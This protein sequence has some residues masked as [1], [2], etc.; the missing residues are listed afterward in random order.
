LDSLVATTLPS[1]RLQQSAAIARISRSAHRKCAGRLKEQGE[2]MAQTQSGR[3]RAGVVSVVARRMRSDLAPGVVLL[4][5]TAVAL[6]W[7]NSPAGDGY[8]ALWDTRLGWEAAGLRLDA[9]HWVNDALMTVFFFVI[10]LEIK[11][12][13]VAGQLA[14]PRQAA[15]P[16]LAAIG[17]AAVPAAV[18]LALTWGS[19]AA[20]GWGVPMATDPAF[21]VGI[22]ALVARHV[23]AA[24]R[25]LLLG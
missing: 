18:F 17:G 9:R 6:V 19:P 15:V 1:G 3:R 12:E 7:V 20:P 16:A 2:D 25:V 22:L 23:P 14:H 11:H 4:A 10:G 8:T 24:V 21:A 13:L 5:A